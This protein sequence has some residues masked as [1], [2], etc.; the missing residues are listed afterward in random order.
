MH[1]PKDKHWARY[2]PEDRR[3]EIDFPPTKT[4]P[5]GSTYS[6]ANFP[7]EEWE[8]MKHAE[9][10]ARFFAFRIR[11]KYEFTRIK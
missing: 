1:P 9:N 6:Y 2:Y 10:A 8:A 7:V 3:V 5:N 4:N 11:G